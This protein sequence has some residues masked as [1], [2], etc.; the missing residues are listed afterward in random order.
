MA[1]LSQEELAERSGLAR[2]YVGLLERGER[3]ATVNALRRIGT[4]L[5]VRAS[6]L[7]AEAEDELAAEP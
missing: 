7:V 1:G 4:A 5:G 3:N 2:N 6:E